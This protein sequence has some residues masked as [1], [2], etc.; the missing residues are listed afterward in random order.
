[1]FRK[2]VKMILYNGKG[3]DYTYQL[4]LL[5]ALQQTRPLERLET[6]DFN[7]RKN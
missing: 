5:A 6:V 2:G 7:E 1:M 3:K 4:L